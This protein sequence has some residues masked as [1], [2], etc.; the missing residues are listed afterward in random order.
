MDYSAFS[1]TDPILGNVR[2]SKLEVKVLE[3]E[4]LQRLR[5][6]Y[7]NGFLYY[8]FPG[9][10][11]T[12]FEHSIGVMYISSRLYESI[13]QR[14]SL[15]R[16]D[17]QEFQEFRLAALL[18]DIGHGPFS[19]ISEYLLE[20][21]GIKNDDPSY[22]LKGPHPY[23]EIET[24]KKISSCR[25]NDP[26]LY[27]LLED[28]DPEKIARWSIGEHMPD[29]YDYW[30]PELIKSDFDADRMDYLLRDSY[31]TGVA[32]GAIDLPRILN[33]KTFSTCDSG[34]APRNKR[35]LVI[36]Y[37][38]GLGLAE[39][40]LIARGQ[41]YPMVILHSTGRVAAAMLYRAFDALH[42]EETSNFGSIINRFMTC[43]DV[44]ALRLLKSIPTT[45]EMAERLLFRKL[46]K[47]LPF[48]YL[49][50]RELHPEVKGVFE[51]ISKDPSKL[52]DWES[53]IER[54]ICEE[55]LNW[56]EE[57]KIPPIIVDIPA[58]KSLDESKALVY[59]EETSSLQRVLEISDVGRYLRETSINKWSICVYFDPYVKDSQINHRLSSDNSGIGKKVK[60]YFTNGEAADV[61]YPQLT[62][63]ASCFI[64]LPIG[65]G[66]TGSSARSAPASAKCL[67]LIAAFRSQ[68]WVVPQSGQVHSRSFR[69]RS[70][71]R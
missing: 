17:D 47:K 53:S 63:G 21:F 61:N 19:H 15:G 54:K 30:I 45:E 8:V 64:P 23:H 70:A 69:V 60:A 18:H 68:S 22:N 42:R 34:E 66:S 51:H 57:G 31:F 41:M 6:I 13:H 55:V 65:S 46:Y 14:F 43:G 2:F 12:R 27:K 52:K 50:W 48:R 28:L 40:I 16:P 25:E 20:R 29:E 62:Q 58:F 56:S 49:E 5:R 36:D 26:D 39:S 32:Y 1:Y 59:D 7:Q 10:F 9:A 38:S 3:N 44:E 35:R 67:I 11:H 37:K 4:N 71:F 24:Y 33:K